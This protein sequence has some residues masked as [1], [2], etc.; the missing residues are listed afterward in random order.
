MINRVIFETLELG[1]LDELADALLNED[2]YRYIGGLPS[3]EKFYRATSIALSGPPAE[4]VGEFWV[5]YGVRE[6]MSGQLIGRIEATV[7]NSIAE[8]AFLFHPTSWGKGYGTESLLWLHG[9]LYSRSDVE[10]LWATTVPAN[11]RSNSL[12][13]RCGYIAVSPDDA[14]KLYT[15]DVGDLVFRHQK[16]SKGNQSESIKKPNH[17]SDATSE[18]APGADS[19]SHQ[20]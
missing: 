13:R 19:S 6:A 17:A 9:V 11:A 20:G 5:N 10:S 8:V 15:Y 7:H 1:H 2:V 14:P 4:R 12:L 3:R 18:P 16:G